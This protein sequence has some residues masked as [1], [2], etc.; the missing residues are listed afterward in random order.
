MMRVLAALLIFYT[1]LF[2]APFVQDRSVVLALVLFCS[3]TALALYIV[4]WT[5]GGAIIT[6][7]LPEAA[8]RL[9]SMHAVARD[10]RIHRKAAAVAGMLVVALHVRVCL[11]ERVQVRGPSMVPTL[12]AGRTLWIEKLS[13]GRAGARR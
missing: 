5:F 7:R 2:L 11:V 13:T 8:R 10:R 3:G 4:V 6:R 12:A 1:A 9:R